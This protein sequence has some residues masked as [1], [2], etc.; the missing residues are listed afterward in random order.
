[1]NIEPRIKTILNSMIKAIDDGDEILY[2][3]LY[4]KLNELTLEMI[5]EVNKE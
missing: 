1:M 4:E 5:D 2:F 3:G